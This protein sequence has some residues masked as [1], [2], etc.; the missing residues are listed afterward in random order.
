MQKEW[1]WHN[2]IPGWKCP[3]YKDGWCNGQE[4]IAWNNDTVYVG[5]WRNDKMEGRGTFTWAVGDMYAE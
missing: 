4:M 2:D 1:P 3:W 5:E